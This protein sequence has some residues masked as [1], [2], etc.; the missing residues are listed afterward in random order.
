MPA[1]FHKI[2]A[3]NI[4]NTGI[5]HY[6]FTSLYILILFLFAFITVHC[7]KNLIFYRQEKIMFLILCAIEIFISE[8]LIVTLVSLTDKGYKSINTNLEIITFLTIVSMFLFIFFLL[9]LGKT[10]Y[11]N[12]ILLEKQ[13]EQKQQA[14]ELQMLMEATS[15]LRIMKHDMANHI[16]V[17]KKLLQR[18]DI[19]ELMNYWNAYELELQNTNHLISSGNTII[20]CVVTAK[21]ET[22]NNKGIHTIHSIFLP[23]KIPI[24]GLHLSTLLANLFNNAIEACNRIDSAEIEKIIELH[25]KPQ[26]KMLEICMKNSYNGILH[27]TQE[28]NGL[29]LS[30]KSDATAHISSGLGLQSIRK[31]VDR[32]QGIVHIVPTD[33]FFCINI[34]IPLNDK[35]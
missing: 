16:A 9:K 20:D 11:D 1:L 27:Q 12:L 5:I 17:S 28:N 2:D 14:S 33:T 15:N 24:E 23:D 26:G 10:R 32:Y 4:I 8:Y 3:T 19:D 31:I 30:S 7:R 13:N 6:L 29:L 21:L 18:N 34:Y 25:I 22:S 35:F